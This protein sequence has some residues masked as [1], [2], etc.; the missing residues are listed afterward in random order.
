MQFLQNAGG[1]LEY[2]ALEEIFE[3]AQASAVGVPF[4]FGRPNT[5]GVARH[6]STRR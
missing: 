4:A 1:W 6:P 2:E 3:L 5:R